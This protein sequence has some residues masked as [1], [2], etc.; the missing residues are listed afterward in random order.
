M[1]VYVEDKIILFVYILED[2]HYLFVLYY[3]LD[4]SLN[5]YLII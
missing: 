1:Q 4:I 2:I 5:K 3:R